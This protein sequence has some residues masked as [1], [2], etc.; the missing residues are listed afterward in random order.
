MYKRKKLLG[1]LL[2][3][4]LL[5][6][7]CSQR[8]EQFIVSSDEDGVICSAKSSF[9]DTIFYEN[10][11]P[12]STIYYYVRLS[13]KENSELRQLVKNLKSEKTIPEFSLQPGGAT[14]SVASDATQ[15][16][17]INY[18]LQSPNVKKIFTLFSEKSEAMKPC[19]KVENFWNIEG[20]AAPDNPNPSVE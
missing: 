1:S 2:M 13:E 9:N 18:A 19:G 20:V 12:D 14:F 11:F 5:F 8:Q 15:F 10:R 3:A 17:Q 6:T 16:Y 7:A 4:G